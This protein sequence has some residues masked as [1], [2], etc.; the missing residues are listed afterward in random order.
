MTTTTK[1]H[2]GRTRVEISD[3]SH[4][5]AAIPCLLGFRPANAIVLISLGGNSRHQ[6]SALM[7]LDLPEPEA[8]P[9]VADAVT[10]ALTGSPGDTVLIVVIGRHA[11]HQPAHGPPHVSLV[12]RLAASVRR[13]GRVAD[14][15]AWVPEIRAGARWHSYWDSA[16]P[17]EGV[18]PDESTTVMA[19]VSAVEGHVTFDSR[20]EMER[21]LRP[22]EPAALE[23][24]AELLRAAVDA[25]TPGLPADQTFPAYARIVRAAIDQVRRGEVAFTDDQV[26]RLTMALCEPEIRDACL[27]LALPPARDLSRHAQRL[28]LELVRLVPAPERAEPAALLG[29]SAYVR[30]EGP[31]ALMAFDN[32][33][34]ANPGHY[35][36]RLLRAGLERGLPPKA[37][38]R[39]GDCAQDLYR[40][41]SLGVELFSPKD[42]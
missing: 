18:L 24:R 42:P 38:R 35:L 13:L 10:T 5:I 12:E 19:A 3:P 2:D 25:L 8:E 21:Q 29:Y 6:I 40:P 9:D 7:R 14:F 1:W 23:R 15:A 33:L 16:D 4:L 27:R 41:P 37:L 30:G 26:V 39:L 17:G 22:D 32:A 11:D 20:E 34:K 28:W 36:T 31:L